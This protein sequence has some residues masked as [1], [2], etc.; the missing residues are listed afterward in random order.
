MKFLLLIPFNFTYFLYFSALRDL[1]IRKKWTWNIY[2]FT[3]KLCNC[4]AAINQ[5][6]T[7]IFP[8]AFCWSSCDKTPFLSKLTWQLSI[9]NAPG[10]TCNRS[11]N[12]LLCRY[13]FHISAIFRLPHF[14][15]SLHMQVL[16][17]YMSTLHELL[18]DIVST[19]IFS[20]PQ[21]IKQITFEQF[22]KMPTYLLIFSPFWWR[23]LIM[24]YAA[25]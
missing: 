18:F 9:S 16:H 7:P 6:S 1:H 2:T 14:Q 24:I 4:R 5:T 3:T 8:S 22:M 21:R 23:C 13:Y 20:C 15:I 11:I 10:V 25:C 12:E 19:L 17:L